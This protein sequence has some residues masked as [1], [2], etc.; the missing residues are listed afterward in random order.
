MPSVLVL[1]MLFSVYAAN[2]CCFIS[3]YISPY[4]EGSLFTP[5]GEW[6]RSGC[7]ANAGS[8]SCFPS[9]CALAA[10]LVLVGL[11]Y[12]FTLYNYSCHS[13]KF[14]TRV[15][16]LAL[17]GAGETMFYTGLGSWTS[18]FINRTSTFLNGRPF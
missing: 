6:G 9:L 16:L 5:G 3:W 10:P 2:V 18:W 11:R 17:A 1:A 4:F 14:C 13:C 8:T 15:V 7:V 12:V